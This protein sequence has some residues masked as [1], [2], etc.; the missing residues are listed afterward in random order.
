MI[1]GPTWG[2]V[3]GQFQV[4]YGGGSG[5]PAT[6][7]LPAGTN[8][9]KKTISVTQNGQAVDPKCYSL[10]PNKPC[11]ILNTTVAGCETIAD[12]PLDIHYL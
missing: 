10:D 11:L 3:Q 12:S 9:V 2:N 1:S 6:A 7:C 4:S 5:G 8:V